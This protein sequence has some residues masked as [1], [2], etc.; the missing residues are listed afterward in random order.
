LNKV[1]KKTGILFWGIYFKFN[2]K[3]KLEVFLNVG[4][5]EISFP[6]KELKK[7]RIISE[8]L[9]L[10]FNIIKLYHNVFF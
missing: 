8:K 7:V 10:L 4:K 1:S 2:I 9:F 3:L 5:Q 6:V